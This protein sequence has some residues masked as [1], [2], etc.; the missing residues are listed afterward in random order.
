MK[1]NRNYHIIIILA[2]KEGTHVTKSEDYNE[3]E[4]F[5]IVWP[6]VIQ[7][8]LSDNIL[9][10]SYVQICYI[11]INISAK[12]GDKI[13]LVEHGHVD[14]EVFLILRC[15]SQWTVK[16]FMKWHR[17]GH[18]ALDMAMDYTLIEEAGRIHL[19]HKL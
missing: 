15:V 10:H 16:V 7:P 18:Q 19:T 9:H 1:H 6:S 13:F 14:L 3:V 17:L 4:L 5:D 2:K 11:L 12:L 8:F